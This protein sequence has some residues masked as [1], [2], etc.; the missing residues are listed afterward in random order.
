MVRPMAEL[1]AELQRLAGRV[2]D[3]AGAANVW[4]GTTDRE[5]VAALN[6]RAGNPVGSFKEL[7]GVLNQL[8]GTVGLE[9]QGAAQRIP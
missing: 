2:L 1:N 6:V 7:A 3:R 8:A 9:A 4:A 5:V